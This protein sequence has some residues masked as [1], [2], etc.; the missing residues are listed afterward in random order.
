MQRTIKEAA[1]MDDRHNAIS[2]VGEPSQW[3]SKYLK[4]LKVELQD[5]V[6]DVKMMIEVCGRREKS[7]E[8]T[9]YVHWQNT[10]LFTREIKGLNT[11]LEDLE[12]IDPSRYETQEEMVQYINRLFEQSILKYDFPRVIH[13][14]VK[15]KLAKVSR[16][17]LSSHFDEDV[18]NS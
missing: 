5:I 2:V 3:R 8:I 7:G 18:L 16:Y 4:V 1:H 14:K 15:R 10:G 11:L 13:I 17:L 9:N 6:D 12:T